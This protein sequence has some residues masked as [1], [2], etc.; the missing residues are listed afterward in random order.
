MQ[1]IAED[2]AGSNGSAGGA[3]GGASGG[4]RGSRSTAWTGF[5]DTGVGEEGG[6][7]ATE[8][9]IEEPE[10]IGR[11]MQRRQER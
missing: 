10:D 7:G 6:R 3:V 11:V 5:G 1:A 4:H 2:R 9:R 8:T